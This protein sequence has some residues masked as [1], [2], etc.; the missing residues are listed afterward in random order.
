LYNS[1]VFANSTVENP[2]ADTSLALAMNGVLQRVIQATNNVII[3]S[4]NPDILV[5]T[6]GTLF[7][8][9]ER[10]VE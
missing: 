5:P 1:N 9:Q 3:R 7:A 10:D 2:V 4:G 8:I 6:N